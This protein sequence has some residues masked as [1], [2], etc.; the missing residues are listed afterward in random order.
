M[1][2]IGLDSQKD[3]NAEV[4]NFAT[5]KTW[6]PPWNPHSC[7]WHPIQHTGRGSRVWM[8]PTKKNH[9]KQKL[10]KDNKYRNK[11]L[12]PLSCLRLSIT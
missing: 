8:V 12:E 1:I 9:A 5:L 4:L 2:F 6:A 3:L 7:I 11:Q 10:S